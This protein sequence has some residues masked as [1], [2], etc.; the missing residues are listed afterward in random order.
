MVVVGRKMATSG[1]RNKIKIRKTTNEKDW[2]PSTVVGFHRLYLV[3]IDCRWFPFSTDG[4]GE[5]EKRK[6]GGRDDGCLRC[7]TGQSRSLRNKAEWM[8]LLT[9]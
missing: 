1:R 7:R 9:P 6:I 3:N 2:F 8:A 4:A 5:T